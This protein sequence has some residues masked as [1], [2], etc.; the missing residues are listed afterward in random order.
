[1]TAV[2][3]A[4]GTS[5]ASSLMAEV[6]APVSDQTHSRS[7]AEHSHLSILSLITLTSPYSGPGLAHTW[8]DW[9]RLWGQWGNWAQTSACASP[10]P[11]HPLS[12]QL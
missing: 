10:H 4:S 2:S 3:L 6:V 9:A 1:M 5:V 12:L 7:P 8:Q 11:P